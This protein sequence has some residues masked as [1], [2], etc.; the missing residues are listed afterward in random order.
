MLLRTVAR[1]AASASL[2]LAAACSD[3]SGPGGSSRVTVLLTDA[4]GDILEAVVT[5]DQIYLQ[6]GAADDAEGGRL[7]LLDEPVTVDLL[8]LADE[9]MTLVEG[10]EIPEGQYNQLRFVISGAYLRV[11]QDEGDKVY[12][13]SPDYDGLPP[14]TEVGGNLLMPGFDASGLKVIFPGGLVF[15]DEVSV[16]VD[17]DVAESF[18]QQAGQSGMWVMHPVLKGSIL[19]PEAAAAGRS[20]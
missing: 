8:T 17:F 1:V 6:G 14:D 11:E 18:G 3:A 15:E 4:P 10:V 20:R 12:A 2:V 9:W 7:V 13:S 16:L 19:E 5:I